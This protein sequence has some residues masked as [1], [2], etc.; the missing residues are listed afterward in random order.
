MKR[1]AFI[2][3]TSI[4]S[5][6]S[7]A[8]S[9]N[10][11][12][13]TIGDDKVTKQEFIDLY[14]KNNTDPNKAI[15]KNDLNEYLDLFINYKLK[16]KEA[17]QL[18]M[19]TMKIY[20]D[21]LE[22]YRKQLINPYINDATITEQII[23]EAYDRLK[24]FVRASHILINIPANATPAD[25][26]A[27]YNKALEIRKKALN[28]EAFQALAT[29]YSDDPSVKENKG[30]LGYFTSMTMIYPFEQACYTM[31]AGDISELVRTNFGYHIIK[32]TERKPAPFYTVDVAHIWVNPKAH[33]S[34][35]NCKA[36]ID[37]AYSRLNSGESFEDV[38]KGFSDD[39]QTKNKGGILKG[40]KINN[41]LMEYV[42]KL[43]DLKIGE[44][45][46]PFETRFGW[47]IVKPVA[48]NTLP[49][50]NDLRKT[51]E[52]RISG[53]VRSY[54]TIEAFANKVKKEYGFKEDLSKLKAVEDIITDS[55]FSATWSVPANFNK[56][57]EIF[58]IGDYSFTQYDMAEYIEKNQKKE[59]HMYIP[60]FVSKIY[61]DAVL[62]SVVNYGNKHLESK[63]PELK[64]QLDEFRNGVLIFAI[65][66]KYVWNKSVTDTAGLEQ[67]YKAHKQNYMWNKR[68]DATIW[69]LDTIVNLE[70]ALSLITKGA[71]KGWTNIEIQEKIAK[72]CKLDSN[73]IKQ[74]K[75]T[76]NKFEKGDNKFVDK[77][78][79]QV[80]VGLPT[81]EGSKNYIVVVHKIV[82]PEIKTLAEC[83]GITT[84]DY[85]EYLEKEWIKEL[86]QKY[87]YKV[88]K[89]VFNS[90]K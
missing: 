35:A 63:Y 21:E 32:L 42:I 83:K 89:D 85:Q 33:D 28:G 22:T 1:I 80:G 27:A 2:L 12:I 53:D 57:E 26:L 30:D 74:V 5:I 39:V 76:W 43:Q 61:K 84:S 34:D 69:T 77:S 66:D 20:Q 9:N 44:Y 86:R 18:G 73:F 59:I 25:T 88:N 58:R 48:F 65:T 56:K 13:L 15:D 75:F 16:L 6:Y 45:S 67:F 40:Q 3:A 8:Q 31:K 62:E 41:L 4:F 55:V 50:I 11:I 49:P 87:P 81:C 17:H 82:E 46:Q 72:K 64:S 68:S 19:D 79:Q 70:K 29:E 36:I 78:N 37:E 47:H 23:Q 54:R 71:K 10:D 52:R 60:A 38:V 7:Y 14:Q 90:I 51:I 24:T